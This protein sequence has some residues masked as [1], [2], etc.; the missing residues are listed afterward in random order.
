MICNELSRA[1]AVEAATRVLSSLHHH[2]NVGLRYKLCPDNLHG[3]SDSDWA[4]GH[5]STSDWVCMYGRAAISWS[6]KKQG[7]V[8]VSSCEAD[9]VAASEAA[10]EAVY[11]RT[12]FDEAAWALAAGAYVPLS[13]LIAETL[14]IWRTTRNTTSKQ[15]TS[16]GG[17][18]H[19]CTRR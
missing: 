18:S 9:I 4:V 1:R 13:S 5:D 12:L 19:L 3:H 11:L 7:N 17:I 8:A 10:K 2:R 16:A 6:S 14:S 15:S